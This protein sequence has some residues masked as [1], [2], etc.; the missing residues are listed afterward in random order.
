MEME[1]RT[2]REKVELKD[3]GK[4]KGC[5]KESGRGGN[6]KK[7]RLRFDV[8]LDLVVRGCQTMSE[9]HGVRWAG[10]LLVMETEQERV[11]MLRRNR[12]KREIN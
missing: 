3:D 12:N 1:K 7:R 9:W 11:G 5:D 6:T 2:E 4:Q 8:R 10:R